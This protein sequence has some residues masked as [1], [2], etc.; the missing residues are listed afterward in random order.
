MTDTINNEKRIRKYFLKTLADPVLL[1]TVLGMMSIMYHYRSSLAFAYGAAAYVIGW[2]VF[3]IFDYVNKHHFI[4]FLICI[5]LYIFFGYA[6]SYAMKRG[7]EGYSISWGL[8]FFT[9]Q[10]ALKYNKWYTIAVFIL[11]LIF[12]LSVIYYF[13]RVRYR[14]F[15]NFLVFIIPFTIYGKEYEKENA[16]A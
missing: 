1:Y 8:W 9:P 2:L 13:T 15:M 7:E 6:A 12:M 16:Y 11:F 4:G 14:I 3:R 10:D 5:I